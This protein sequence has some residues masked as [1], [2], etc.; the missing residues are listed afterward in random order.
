MPGRNSIE[1]CRAA[2]MAIVQRHLQTTQ[3]KTNDPKITVTGLHYRDG[4]IVFDVTTGGDV[5]IE[6]IA[7]RDVYADYRPKTATE[8]NMRM[9]AAMERM[10]F[11][12][13]CPECGVSPGSKHFLH[14]RR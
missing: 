4:A 2:L 5:H 14:C 11:A 13:H 3:G 1:Y 8:I 9:R 7:T 12:P 6:S 10:T